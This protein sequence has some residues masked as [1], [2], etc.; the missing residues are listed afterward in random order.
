MN[1]A[2]IKGLSPLVCTH[3][4]YL[5]DNDKPSR[6]IKQ[7]LQNMI[8][9]NHKNCSLR[10]NDALWAY[11]T[12]YKNILGMFPYRLI[13]GKACHLIVELKHKLY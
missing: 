8:N 11:Y 3:K 12:A 2:D 6:D 7:I 5:E 10:L 4:I 9:P 13:Y 1:V